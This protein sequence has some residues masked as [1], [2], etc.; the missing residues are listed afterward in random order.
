MLRG[1]V[2]R[3]PPYQHRSNWY[4][5]QQCTTQ[6]MRKA[7]ERRGEA[8]PTAPPI[9][10]NTTACL[11]SAWGHGSLANPHPPLPAHSSSYQCHT[12]ARLGRSQAPSLQHTQPPSQTSTSAFT[13]THGETCG[14]DPLAH[15]QQSNGKLQQVRRS[16]TGTGEGG[17]G[18]IPPP[19]LHPAWM[20]SRPSC[21]PSPARASSQ[22]H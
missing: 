2:R 14:D 16:P 19:A 18:L 22:R 4:N 3:R 17:K 13:R 12:H 8:A 1:C 9:H 7:H 5:T 6:H 15:T 20:W 21:P 10:R 11:C